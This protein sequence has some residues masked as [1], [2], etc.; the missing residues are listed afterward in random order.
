MLFSIQTPT[1]ANMP[2]SDKLIGE[3]KDS[4][5]LLITCPMYNLQIPSALKA[6]IDHIVR[7][8]ETFRYAVHG[9]RGLLPGKKTFI[10]ATMGGPKNAPGSLGEHES[11]LKKIL[12]F[13]GIETITTL[14]AEGTADPQHAPQSVAAIKR[15]IDQLL[16]GN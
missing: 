12:E 11:Y 1:Q 15:D 16:P 6:Y 2:L 10:V 4:D 3:I 8:N 13:M 7:I 5:E 9:H 14:C